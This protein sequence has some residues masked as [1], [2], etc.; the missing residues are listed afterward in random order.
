MLG[1]WLVTVPT[2][3][4]AKIGATM[5]VVGSAVVEPL[6]AELVQDQPMLSTKSMSRS[7][8]NSMAAA[9]V[10][11]LDSLRL[12][13]A[14]TTTPMAATLALRQVLL[15]L[16]LLGGLLVVVVVEVLDPLEDPLHGDSPVEAVVKIA[17]LVP[18]LVAVDKRTH[19]EAG[20][21]LTVEVPPHGKT[22]VVVHPALL[23]GNNSDTTI[24][25]DSRTV[26]MVAALNTI[27]VVMGKADMV[28]TTVKVGMVVNRVAT[29]TTSLLLLHRPPAMMRPLLLHQATILHRLLLPA[30]EW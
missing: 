14:G 6:L 15:L 24:M 11:L 8:P 28:K 1:T 9:L 19:M 25:V 29:G 20:I 3:L 4:V 12:V 23:P 30:L 7:W 17:N 26:V 13:R 16:L 22:M 27:R 18:G 5:T 21:T 10:L 2:V